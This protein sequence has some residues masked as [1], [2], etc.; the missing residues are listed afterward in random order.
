MFIRR[1]EQYIEEKKLFTLQDKVLVAF[2][3]GPDSVA[4]LRC[5]LSLGYRCEC[6][7]CNFH[8]RGE[9]SDRD[10]RFV[11][12]LCS[13]LQ[14]PLHVVHF[15]TEAY[16]AQKHLSI[17]MAAREL[18]YDW[19]HRLRGEVGARVIAVAHHRDDSVETFLL[20]LIRGTGIQGLKGIAPV[21]GPVV[22]PL[23]QVGREEIEEYLHSL[24]QDSV[25]D[26]TNLQ[27]EFTR[28]KIRLHLLPFLKT[29][30]P[31]IAEGLSE[32]ADRLREV[33]AVYAQDRERTIASLVKGNRETSFSVAID[34]VLNDVAPMSLLHELL[35]PLG[36]NGSQL[37]DIYRS[38]TAQSGRVFRSEEWEVLRDRSSLLVQRLTDVQRER[39]PELEYTELPMTEDFQWPKDSSVACLDADLVTWPLTVRHWEL[40]DKFVPLGMKGRKK[41]S[42]Y[43]TNRKYSLFE[44]ERLCVACSGEEIVWLINE[45]MDHRFRITDSTRRILMVRVKQG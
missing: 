33:A 11:R 9:E 39:L 25:T 30:N 19:F 32:T 2:S 37:K 6:A 15:Q 26:S 41:V 14:V 31:S 36:F 20:N 22:R 21:N 29:M 8:L 42:D 5:L 44:K 38:L 18:R 27:D 17:E 28:N 34:A 1:I 13:S 12:S 45:R 7:H 10:E 23:L 4:L 3:G 43:L 40:G 35:Y 16:A 24:G